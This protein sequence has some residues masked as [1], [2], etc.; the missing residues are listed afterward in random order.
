MAVSLVEPGSSADGPRVLAICDDNM[1]MTVS[2]SRPSIDQL[3]VRDVAVRNCSCFFRVGYGARLQPS[4]LCQHSNLGMKAVVAILRN[5][6]LL[7]FIPSV[8][9]HRVL[10]EFHR[11]CHFSEDKVSRFYHI[12]K[13]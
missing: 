11:S 7:E 3:Q 4:R 5:Y 2:Q 12:F 13:L 6:F 1:G 9:V 10:F 8:L